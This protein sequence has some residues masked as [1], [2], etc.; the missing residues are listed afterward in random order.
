M[1]SKESLNMGSGT[2]LIS[3]LKSMLSGLT[4]QVSG[5]GS[6]M[7]TLHG[8]SSGSSAGGTQVAPSPVFSS[9][10]GI[11]PMSASQSQNKVA[12]GPS[13]SAT[14]SPSYGGATNLTSYIQQN[15][16]RGTL[17][18]GSGGGSGGSSSGG[19]GSSSSSSGGFG[20]GFGGIAG[21]INTITS[22]VSTGIN[23]VMGVANKVGS[24]MPSTSDLVETNLLTQRASFFNTDRSLSTNGYSAANNLQNTIARA[25]TVTSPLD[26]LRGI[27]AAQSYGIMGPNFNDVMSGI[28]NVS[29][30][31]PGAGIEGT[32]RAIGAM[33]SGHSVNMLKAIGI[34]I[35][36]EN[37]NLV[38]P[39]QVIDQIWAKLCKDVSRSGRTAAITLKDVQIGLQQGN[40]LDSMLNTYFG[41]DPI[42]K[43]M[44]ANGLIFKA[45][46]SGG[47]SLADQASGGPAITKTSV[48]NAGG[49]TQAVSGVSS[50]SAVNAAA[51]QLLGAGATNLAGYAQANADIIAGVGTVEATLIGGAVQN[52]KE[53][54]D[55]LL[56]GTSTANAGLAQAGL[57]AVTSLF[58]AV[59]GD[60][61]TAAQTAATLSSLPG[62]AVGGPVSGNKP[63]L[64]GEKGPEIFVPSTSGNIIPNNQLTKGSGGG[65]ATYNFTVN[66]P[67]ANT[68][69]V[70]AA[71]KNMVAE[72]NTNRKISDS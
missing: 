61:K 16:N 60:P 35:R 68:P 53:Q 70:I 21:V 22:A 64:I 43:Q 59:N 31:V 9:A 52:I 32:T 8:A 6:A 13:I 50:S 67:S 72:L 65:T 4:Q 51:G 7:H 28:A 62:K 42:L 20:F 3:N 26:A 2:N 66:L 19:G 69:E 33:Q 10:P 18:S 15:P 63:Y 57:D 5:L 48:L 54:M 37:G 30:L 56:A 34:K 23:A 44:I 39:D 71:L 47:Q 49:T 46:S 25:G 24:V 12:A 38:P 29:N 27:T 58:N 36:D 14:S 41:S 17:F 55:V 1:G 40:S 11:V 45:Q